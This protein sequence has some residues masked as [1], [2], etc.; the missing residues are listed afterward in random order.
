MK[1]KPS[2]MSDIPNIFLTVIL[3]FSS[4]FLYL[5]FDSVSFGVLGVFFFF[6]LLF[7]ILDKTSPSYIIE[8]GQLIVE[9]GTIWKKNEYI[10]LFRVKDIS[11][12]SNILLNLFNIG[13]IN[14]VTTDSTCPEL[15]IKMVKDYKNIAEIIRKK[16]LIARKDNNMQ[17]IDIE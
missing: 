9:H 3:L 2:K 7:F 10:E 11:T 1:F 4:V 13:N 12:S 17:E 8:D 14:V 15:S 5:F 6:C 16:G